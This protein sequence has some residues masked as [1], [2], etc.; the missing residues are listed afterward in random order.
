MLLFCVL[1][2]AFVFVDLIGVVCL[3][4]VV[5]GFAFVVAYLILHF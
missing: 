3:W 2:F 4:V 5:C 1:L